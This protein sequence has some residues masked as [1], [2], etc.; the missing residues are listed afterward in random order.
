MVHWWFGAR[1]FG[2][3]GFLKMKGIVIDR[4]TPGIP[5]H[6]APNQQLTISWMKFRKKH[7]KNNP[8]QKLPADFSICFLPLTLGCW[9]MPPHSASRSAVS[10][11]V[12]QPEKTVS[13]HVTR[14]WTRFLTRD[15]KHT[16]FVE[17]R[18]GNTHASKHQ[19]R[20]KKDSKK[21]MQ[22]RERKTMPDSWE[23]TMTDSSTHH[24][25]ALG[26]FNHLKPVIL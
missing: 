18:M 26:I 14:W 22:K 23:L 20:Q 6:R 12:A 2:L 1:S 17:K 21:Q 24:V 25:G 8:Q 10:R 4:G 7:Y 13:D 9:V 15:S 5:N 19:K 3:L 11:D 16:P